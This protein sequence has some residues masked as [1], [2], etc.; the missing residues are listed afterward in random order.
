MDS[1]CQPDDLSQVREQ[2]PHWEVEARWIVA[3]TWP[4]RHYLPASSGGVTS[5]GGEAAAI[6]AWQHQPPSPGG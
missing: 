5:V 6:V 3:G 4:D 1:S 2:F